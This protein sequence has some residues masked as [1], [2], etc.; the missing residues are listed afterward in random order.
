MLSCE[1]E[2]GGVSLRRDGEECHK[3]GGV[4]VGDNYSNYIVCQKNPFSF[5]K[6]ES[7]ISDALLVHM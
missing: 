2:T 1:K 3:V 7:K 6:I 4:E 5:L